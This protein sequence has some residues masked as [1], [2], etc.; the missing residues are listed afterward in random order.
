MSTG[1]TAGDPFSTELL[2]SYFSVLVNQIFKI[3]PMRESGTETLPKYIWR[4]Q[5]EL[6]GMNSLLDSVR[7][8]PYYGSLLGI[9]SYLSDNVSDCTVGQVRQLVFEA[10]DLSKK[11]S[12]RYAGETSKGA[13]A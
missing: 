12:R 2:R 8:D 7:Q 3:L 9:L 13:T 5:A 4:L 11:L 6:I 1:E 10:M